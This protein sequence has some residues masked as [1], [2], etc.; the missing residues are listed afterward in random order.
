MTHGYR[1]SMMIGE[2]VDGEPMVRNGSNTVVR[3]GRI[4]A[5]LERQLQLVIRGADKELIQH[6]GKAIIQLEH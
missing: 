1:S 4:G 5:K 6:S 3:V 2:S